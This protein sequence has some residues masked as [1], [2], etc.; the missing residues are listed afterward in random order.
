VGAAF[1]GLDLE[2]ATEHGVI[3]M[4]TP[5]T[6]A[7]S[8]A[9]HTLTLLLALSRK[10]VVAH[11]SLKEG[12]WLLDRKRQ[13]GT[14]LHGKTLGI[15]GLGRTGRIVAQRGLAF[16]MAVLANDPYVREE[17]VNDE[18]ISLV[19]L[20]E[21]LQHSDFVSIH[22]PITRETQTMFNE[23]TIG[24]M[25]PG[26]RLINTAHGDVWD[27][28][29]VAHA[30]KDGHL[31]GAAVDVF[32]EEPP[33][34]SPLVGLDSVI[35]TPHIA[36]NTVEAA[37]DLSIQIVNQVL[38][39]L[40]EVDYRNA[41]NLP[42]MP[43]MDFETIRPYLNLAERMGKL[44]HL[45]ARNPVCR[46]AVELR[47]EEVGGLVKP[48]TVALLKGLLTPVLGDKVSYINAPLLASERGM[49]ITQTKGLEVGH[50]TNQVSCQVELENGEEIIMSG[51][52]LDHKVPHI[53]QINQYVMSFV[54]EGHL[55]VMGSYDKPGVIGRVGT[56]LASN[57]VN[58]GSWQTGRAHP[59]GQTLT[60]LSLDEPIPDP[61]LDELRAQDFV[62]HAHGI[63]V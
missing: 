43:G 48:L 1:S 55:L 44:I 8:T 32:S 27:E 42:F 6:S 2:T 52:L 19:G 46:M 13:A 36:E 17:Q 31:A 49:R 25:K 35:H 28:T 50:Y 16:G 53:V 58:I 23:D 40:R 7:I 59:G 11:N 41:V 18:R 9:E 22:V 37:Q 38:D 15:V 10:L 30:L 34:T 63:E 14:Q 60:V 51:T 57:N 5:G 12:W 62:R 24:L 33:Y 3:V 4:N 47:G 21:L 54:P 39:A 56:L 20:R 26:S 61:V 45:L 29:A